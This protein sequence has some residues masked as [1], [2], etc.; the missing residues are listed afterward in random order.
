MVRSGSEAHFI[1]S[2][3]SRDVFIESR[4]FTV[5]PVFVE[6]VELQSVALDF[7]VVQRRHRVGVVASPAHHSPQL[8]ADLSN[9]EVLLG[10]AHS[11]TQPHSDDVF[12]G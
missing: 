6:D 8:V 9:D 10:G 3:M 2:D 12:L 1:P 7:E 11:V 4:Y 5:A